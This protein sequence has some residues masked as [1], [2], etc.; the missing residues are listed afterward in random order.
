MLVDN[1]TLS[2][3]I[4][5]EDLL[6]NNFFGNTQTNVDR[7]MRFAEDEGIKYTPR[8]SRMMVM[9]QISYWEYG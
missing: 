6:D 5:V 1:T 3:V 7:V 4:K 2:E 9:F 8:Q